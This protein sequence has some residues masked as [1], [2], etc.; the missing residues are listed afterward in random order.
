M[1][2]NVIEYISQIGY[3]DA[4]LEPIRIFSWI[5]AYFCLVVS[6]FKFI[7]NYLATLARGSYLIFYL[8]L[9][10][11]EYKKSRKIHSSHWSFLIEFFTVSLCCCNQVYDD[12]KR[13]TDLESYKVKNQEKL[14]IET[15]TFSKNL[16]VFWIYFKFCKN[17]KNDSAFIEI[18]CYNTKYI[19]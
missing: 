4:F 19:L 12:N 1:S 7:M 2:H 8:F 16:H 11:C 15:G 9:I 17:F 13:H 18:V 14:P 10:Y 5:I 6:F 3:F